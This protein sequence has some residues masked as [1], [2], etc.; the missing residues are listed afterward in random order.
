MVDA[1]ATRLLIA[2]LAGWES[3]ETTR[4][5]T[6]ARV[7]AGILSGRRVGRNRTEAERLGIVRAALGD[8]WRKLPELL[9]DAYAQHRDDIARLRGDAE[10]I[11]AVF[12]T[13]LTRAPSSTPTAASGAPALD[14]AEAA[15]VREVQDWCAANL[16]L[17]DGRMFR[18]DEAQARVILAGERHTL[19]TA[20]AGSGK[21]ATMVARVAHLVRVRGADPG[22][23]LMLAFNASAAQQLRERVARWVPGSRQPHVR[24]FDAFARAILPD[25]GA[26]RLLAEGEAAREVADVVAR[27]LAD[28]RQAGRVRTALGLHAAAVG[29]ADGVAHTLRGERVASASERVLADTLLRLGLVGGEWSRLDYRVRYGMTLDG[30]WMRPSAA[31]VDAS[32]AARLAIDLGAAPGA[33]SPKDSGSPNVLR[34]RASDTTQPDFIDRLARRL[35]RAGVPTRRLDRDDIWRVLERRVTDSFRAAAEQVLSRA[36]QLRWSGADL[37]A[38]W[39][40]H[41][42]EPRREPL[43][44]LCADVLDAYAARLDERG[45]EDFAGRTWRAVDALV[46]DAPVSG[47]DVGVKKSFI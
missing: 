47:I 15:R 10:A 14:P 46:S 41:D 3:W 20:R 7:L 27:F 25:G 16:P 8:E 6:Y 29:G 22:A 24:T 11:A 39:A 23:I 28:P 32:G 44:T 36:R 33:G 34:L 5:T 19:V 42:G 12:D 38:A 9:D 4:E 35:E 1:R 37:R 43:I 26:M 45:A 2:L 17:D 21:T 40:R 31:L 18:P 13:P 30:T